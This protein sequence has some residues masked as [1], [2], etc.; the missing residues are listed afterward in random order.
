MMFHV[1]VKVEIV[2]RQPRRNLVCRQRGRGLLFWRWQRLRLCAR[3]GLWFSASLSSFREGRGD[4]HLDW[5]DLGND[6]AITRAPIQGKERTRNL[7][8]RHCI[9]QQQNRRRT[10]LRERAA[11]QGQDLVQYIHRIIDRDITAAPTLDELLAPL[12]REFA[13]SGMTE[14]ELDALVEEA[15]QEV[16]QEKQ[17][18]KDS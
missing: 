16:W 12:R 15:R 6:L 18:K 10:Q 4:T 9:W 17:A 3:S 11:A 1:H 8:P 14:D 7:A 5:R 2:S 13:A